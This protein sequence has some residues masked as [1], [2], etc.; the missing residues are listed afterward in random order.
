MAI[1]L[2]GTIGIT[3]PES[4]DILNTAL[5]KSDTT[6]PPTIQNSTGTEVGTFCRAW[7]NFD[8]TTTPPSIRAS[9][10]V[11]GVTRSATGQYVVTLTNALPD[12]NGAVVGTARILGVNSAIVSPYMDT[13]STIQVNT[14]IVTGALTN[15]NPVHLAVFR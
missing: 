2:D 11:S 6:S 8:G 10:N 4:G 3:L 9:F 7:V 1:T 5:I 12:T 14:N 13:S 15:S